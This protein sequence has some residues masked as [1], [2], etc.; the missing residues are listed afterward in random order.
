MNR[1]ICDTEEAPTSILIKPDYLPI[2]Q[3]VKIYGVSRTYLYTLRYERLISHYHLGTKTFIKVS[4][5]E[6]LIKKGKKE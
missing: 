1:K 3:I 5:L 6:D 4:E 2:K